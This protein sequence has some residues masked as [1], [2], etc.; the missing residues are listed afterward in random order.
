MPASDQDNLHTTYTHPDAD[1]H[2]R[3]HARAYT[4]IPRR[5]ILSTAAVA[6]GAVHL[7]SVSAVLVLHPGRWPASVLELVSFPLPLRRARAVY[8]NLFLIP[9]VSLSFCVGTSSP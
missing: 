7:A 9:F 8:F 6:T 1:S 5:W 3:V 2:V 4:Y